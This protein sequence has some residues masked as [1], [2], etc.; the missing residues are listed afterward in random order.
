MCSLSEH[1]DYVETIHYNDTYH[2]SVSHQFVSGPSDNLVKSLALYNS[3]AQKGCQ[4]ALLESFI[5]LRML[6][7]PLMGRLDN[8][9]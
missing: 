2:C 5:T 7:V 1:K 9:F 3:P 6:L 4:Q 8:F